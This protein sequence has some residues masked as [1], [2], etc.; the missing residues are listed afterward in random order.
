MHIGITIVI[1]TL[2]ILG[3]RALTASKPEIKKRKPTAPAPMVRTI[4]VPAANKRV[5]I[6]GQGTVRPLREI[7]VV[8]QVGGKVVFVSTNLVNGGQFKK[9]EVLLRIDPV[10][11]KLAVTLAEAKVKDAES[12]LKLAKEDAAVSKEEWRLLGYDESEENSTPPPLVAK[13]PQLAAAQARLKADRADLEKA[14][15][16]LERTEIKAPFDG[17]V[18]EEEVGIGQ[19]IS[20]G[21]AVAT[22][23]S[24]EAAEIIVPLEDEK[25]AWFHVPDFSPGEGEGALATVRARIAGQDLMWPGR[26][27]RTEGKLDERTRMINVVIRVDRPYAKK[28]PL[29]VGLFVTVGIEGRSFSDAVIIP[30]AAMREGQVVWVVGKDN[31]LRYRNVTVAVIQDNQAV[32]QEGLK[33]GELVVTTPLKAVTDGMAVRVIQTGTGER[34]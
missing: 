11:Y 3:M 14:L 6:R 30:R 18:S 15:L 17:R 21:N 31:R 16:N 27:V 2:G 22:I 19:Y 8:P 9:G 7:G 12:G 34:S 4:V 23:Y 1:V 28:P 32:I 5:D 29:A 25:L 26:V 24:I 33:A 10:D 13:E 20:V